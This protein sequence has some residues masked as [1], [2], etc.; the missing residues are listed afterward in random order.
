MNYILA[1]TR[2]GSMFI[3]S[4]YFQ[5]FHRIRSKYV[6]TAECAHSRQKYTFKGRANERGL[7]VL[8]LRRVNFSVLSLA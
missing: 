5:L 8:F 1:I 6:T 2:G 3:V 4:T 7:R